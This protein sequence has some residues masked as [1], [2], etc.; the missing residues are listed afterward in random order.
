MVKLEWLWQLT[1]LY[2]DFCGSCL[3]MMLRIMTV[4]WCW[5]IVGCHCEFPWKLEGTPL[6][7]QIDCFIQASTPNPAIDTSHVC[8]TGTAPMDIWCASILWW[9]WM[10]RNWKLPPSSWVPCSCKVVRRGPALC[11]QFQ[12]CVASRS[13]TKVDLPCYILSPFLNYYR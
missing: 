4:S 9:R 2:H 10:G 1:E 13:Q 12:P 11:K 7:V 5:F 8:P 6:P 3:N